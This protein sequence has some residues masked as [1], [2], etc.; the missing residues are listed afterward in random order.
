MVTLVLTISRVYQI[1]DF[2]TRAFLED[3]PL[4]LL[5]SGNIMDLQQQ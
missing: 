5:D 1:Q 2:E 4:G 3:L